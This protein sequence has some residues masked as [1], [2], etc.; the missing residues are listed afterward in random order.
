[1]FVCSSTI[2]LAHPPNITTAVAKFMN[3]EE[4]TI[5]S[6]VQLK[7][8]DFFNMVTE[9]LIAKINIS[10]LNLKVT[11]LTYLTNINTI[12]QIVSTGRRSVGIIKFLLPF[13][14]SKFP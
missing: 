6:R 7:F 11:I 10:R 5:Q 9:E 1:M 14:S 4:N 13:L 3:F 12:R 8:I 2:G